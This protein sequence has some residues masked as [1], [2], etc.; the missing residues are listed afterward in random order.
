LFIFRFQ[1][2]SDVLAEQLSS[3]GNPGVGQPAH[4]LFF[5]LYPDAATAERIAAL[6]HEVRR[7]HGLEDP[8]LKTRNLH[9]SLHNLASYRGDQ[10]SAINAAVEAAASIVFP[11]FDIIFDLA[12]SFASSAPKA[13]LVLRGSEGV[14]AVRAFHETMG[15]AMSR[16]GF[17]RP[18]KFEPHVTMLY[19]RRSIPWRSIDLMGWR[20]SEF[21]LVQSIVGKR[22]HIRLRHWAL[23]NAGRDK[24]FMCAAGFIR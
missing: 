15:A 7:Q 9:V 20:V 14:N 21:T 3:F 4:N 11:A 24:P 23:G 22:R 8:P 16:A 19:D 2:S 12:G 13:P 10:R 6:A 18:R 17:G 5:A 1:C